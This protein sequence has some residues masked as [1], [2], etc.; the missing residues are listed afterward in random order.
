MNIDRIVACNDFI[1]K[2]K[3]SM[4]FIN[5]FDNHTE[6]LQWNCLKI[7]EREKKNTI[8]SFHSNET[9][10]RLDHFLL[11]RKIVEKKLL[12]I[13]LHYH[14]MLI[15]PRWPSILTFDMNDVGI[16]GS[17][18]SPVDLGGHPIFHK[19]VPSNEC[20]ASASGFWPN[21]KWLI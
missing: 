6:W 12:G 1:T 19:F 17:H 3:Q 16:C 11:R 7:Q 2:K 13:R 9:Q 4:I 5:I 10:F 20:V 21:K 14:W 18:W 15:D 8:N